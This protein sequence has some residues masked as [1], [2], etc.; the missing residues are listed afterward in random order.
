MICKY[1]VKHSY[2]IQLMTALCTYMTGLLIMRNICFP[3]SHYGAEAVPW[4][5]GWMQNNVPF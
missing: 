5:P 2:V 4:M 3:L 1:V